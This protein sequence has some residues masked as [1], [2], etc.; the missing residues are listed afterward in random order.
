MAVVQIAKYEIVAKI[1]QGA[2]GDVYK[3]HDPVL[4]RFVAIKTLS[5][6]ATP[7]DSQR[8]RLQREAQS[9][10]QLNH[11]NIVTVFE[12]GQEEGTAYIVMELLEGTDLKE[13]IEERALP[14]LA[15][16]LWVLE[17]ICDGLAFAHSKGVVHRDLKPGNIHILKN[18]QVKIMDFGLARW[19]DAAHSATVVGTPY[20]IAPEQ[21]QGAPASAQSDIFSLGAV[22]YE[23]LAGRRPFGGE[24]VPAVLY[25]VVH[26]EP[27]P[28]VKSVP[29]LPGLAGV[30]GRALAKDPDRR[31]DSASEM[32]DT[33]RLMRQALLSGM[34]YDPAAATIA[35]ARPRPISSAFTVPQALSRAVGTAEPIK[36]ALLDLRGY[37]ADRLPPLMI[38][39]S[40]NLLLD[41]PPAEVAP[42]VYAW[43]VGQRGTQVLVPLSDFLIHALRKMCRMGELKLVD[44]ARLY[45]YVRAVGEAILDYCPWEDGDRL[46]EALESLGRAETVAAKL[47]QP[48]QAP[49]KNLAIV[50]RFS[51]LLERLLHGLGTSEVRE[52]GDET[53]R[54]KLVSQILTSAVAL[55]TDGQELDGQLARLSELGVAAGVEQIF[56]SLGQGLSAWMPPP[57]LSAELLGLDETGELQAMRRVIVLAEEPVEMTRRFRGMVYAA[58]EQFN[59]GNLERAVK[60][61]DLAEGMIKEKLLEDG[62]VTTIRRRGHESLSQDR[63]RK[64]AEKPDHH[65]QLRRI[66]NFFPFGLGHM[67]LLG[68]L[69]AEKKRDRRRFLLALLEVHGA[70]ARAAVLEKLEAYRAGG[71][72]PGPYMLRNLAYLLR[73][74]PRPGEESPDREIPVLAHLAEPGRSPAFLAREVVT[75]LGAMKEVQAQQALIDLL[76]LFETEMAREAQGGEQA[77]GEASALLDRICS[78]LA[79]MGTPLAWNA[80]IDHG[81]GRRPEMGP[82]LDRL[83]ELSS[84]DLSGSPPVLA[85]LLG[86]LQANLPR[87]L[88]RF[89]AGK[90]DPELICIIDALS[91]TFTDEVVEAFQAIARRFA[92]H[93]FVPAAVRALEGFAARAKAAEASAVPVRESGE[94]GVFGLPSLLQSLSEKRTGGALTLRDAEGVVIATLGLEGG[95]VRSCQ[96]GRLQSEEAFFQLLEKPFAG[97]YS[98]SGRSSEGESSPSGFLDLA[99]VTAEGIRRYGGL[100]A[101]RALVPDD[102]SLEATGASPTTVP[103]EP[104]YALVVALWEKACAGVTPR[105]CEAEIPADSFRIRRALAHWVEEGALR[106]RVGP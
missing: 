47:D 98:L 53:G 72:D 44:Q 70:P 1:G 58:I 3:A 83:R 27:E 77:R 51:L 2:M 35:G 90:K 6:Q 81:L 17:Q 79:R 85:R 36:E 4:G 31:F 8:L 61:L 52:G 101:A 25:A 32:R 49:P 66:L 33:L 11:P 67:A 40:M 45:P 7:D 87:G 57:A 48:R 22:A 74:I 97:T 55:A 29:E 80:V 63:L 38:T 64:W 41:R 28:L 96:A 9:A 23:F 82:T 18:G 92:G 16:K 54:S 10:A 56:K 24:S 84:Q 14:N 5:K 50:R 93:R 71:D 102:A 65:E 68:E 88:R 86:E 15:D 26:A 106:L 60:M 78:A 43:A 30:V 39:D 99:S 75:G 91:G 12:F 89:W 42:D 95:R 34:R 20:Y 62:E 19:S 103:R 46:R 73:L 69:Q 94:L 37:L 105:Q 76:R 59:A 104:D 21:L 100:Q 13:L